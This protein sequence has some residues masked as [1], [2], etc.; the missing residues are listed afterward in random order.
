MAHDTR[1]S[2]R[3]NPLKEV[4]IP[5]QDEHRETGY[6]SIRRRKASLTSL[7]TV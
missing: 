7:L 5:S 3:S 2:S 4:L 6:K 1:R